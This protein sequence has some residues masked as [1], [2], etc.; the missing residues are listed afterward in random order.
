MSPPGSGYESVIA[1]SPI[2]ERGTALQIS[3]QDAPL[4]G[5][6][7]IRVSEASGLEELYRTQGPVVWRALLA[8]AGDRDVAD[9]ALDEAFA[10]ALARGDGIRDPL[11]WIWRVA[12]RVA[13]GELKDRRSRA[14]LIGSGPVVPFPEPL[15]HVFEALERLSPNQRLAIVLHDYADRPVSEVAATIGASRATVYVHLSQGRRR[16]RALL[17]DDDA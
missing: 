6:Q 3:I 7:D 17:E 10:Q 8:F 5:V 1:S 2:T 9:D 15:L 12:F 4:R 13:A 11:R 16:L 14:E